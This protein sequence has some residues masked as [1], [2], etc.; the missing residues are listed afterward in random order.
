MSEQLTPYV[1]PAQPDLPAVRVV[2]LDQ[3]AQQIDATVYSF[4]ALE[5]VFQHLLRMPEAVKRYG[6]TPGTVESRLDMVRPFTQQAKM[7]KQ[8]A[9]K[10][11]APGVVFTLRAID[12]DA[13][14]LELPG[15]LL[16]GESPNTVYLARFVGDLKGAIKI[17]SKKALRFAM[18]MG[19][20]HPGLVRYK[21]QQLDL[22]H[23]HAFLEVLDLYPRWALPDTHPTQDAAM[24]ARMSDDCGED[25]LQKFISYKPPYG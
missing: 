10:T 1:L 23:A 17:H 21:V 14:K 24:L 11:L 6:L 12:Q 16:D 5:L 7:S 3:K 19:V 13:V 15:I 8:L 2:L 18:S 22:L 25:L 9:G 20:N 4:Q